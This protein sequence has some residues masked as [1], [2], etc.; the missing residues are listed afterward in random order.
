MAKIPSEASHCWEGDSV[1]ALSDEAVP[2]S[3]NDHSI[4]RFTWWPRNNSIEWVQYNFKQP[5]AVS[6]S[7]VYWFDDFATGGGCR[8][9]RSWKLLYKDGDAWKP[10]ANA[11]GYGVQKDRFNSVTFDE[12]TTSALRLEVWLQDDYSGG[13]LEW[14][15]K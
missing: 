11:S 7:E 15:V 10:V 9:P 14:R 1:S 4:A 2:T 6:R 13:I 5:R 8:V 3:S 12:V